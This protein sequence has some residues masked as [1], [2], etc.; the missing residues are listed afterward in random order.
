MVVAS[1]SVIA[2]VRWV[3]L[4]LSIVIGA[5]AVYMG[6]K[7]KGWLWA[8]PVVA[9]SLIEGGFYTFLLVRSVGWIDASSSTVNI[10]SMIRT[11]SVLLLALVGLTAVELEKRK[12]GKR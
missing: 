6:R 8:A 2:I 5:T 4:F 9:G 12:H 10:M 1:A 3:S 11:L 7:Y